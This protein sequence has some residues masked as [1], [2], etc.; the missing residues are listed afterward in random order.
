[1]AHL[2][3]RVPLAYSAVPQ[4]PHD[5]TELARSRPTLVL[6]HGLD[7]TRTAWDKFAEAT[8]GKKWNVLAIDQR[9]HGES[10]LGKEE[11]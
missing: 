3:R 11:E 1:M 10:P 2:G 9:G 7:S 8:A 5:Q 6:I 4:N